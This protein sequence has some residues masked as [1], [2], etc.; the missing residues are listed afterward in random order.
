[1]DVQLRYRGITI[2]TEKVGLSMI[3]RVFVPL[4]LTEIA[5]FDVFEHFWPIGH[6][7]VLDPKNANWRKIL[8][9]GM[10]WHIILNVS[11]PK[12]G[13]VT[14]GCKVRAKKC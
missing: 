2:D 4:K 1:M 7:S 3:S 6:K 11:N 13:W 5:F 8:G 10:P 9:P 12:L 14:V